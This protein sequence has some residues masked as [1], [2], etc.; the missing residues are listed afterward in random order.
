MIDSLNYRNQDVE[1]LTIHPRVLKHVTHPMLL[2][3]LLAIQQ[4]LNATN[5]SRPS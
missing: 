4:L 1:R 2:P 5:D 3:A